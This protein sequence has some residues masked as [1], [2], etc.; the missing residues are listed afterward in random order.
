MAEMIDKMLALAA[1]EHRQRI[2][3]P[4]PVD[5]RATIDEAVER[6]APKLMQRRIATHVEGGAAVVQGDAFLLRQALVNLLDNAADFAPEGSTVTVGIAR[7]GAQWRISVA[8]EGP[9]VPDYA[10]ERAFE[11]FYSLPRPGGGSRSSGLGLCF[12]AEAAALHG[13]EARLA[14]RPGGGAVATLLLPA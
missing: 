12:A 13:G 10:L 11:R 9:G 2:E 5:L 7:D 1:V 6:V 14:N 8:D 3:A 4:Q